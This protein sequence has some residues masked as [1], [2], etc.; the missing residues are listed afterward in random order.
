MGLDHGDMSAANVTA[1]HHC[2]SD[3]RTHGAKVDHYLRP[4]RVVSLVPSWTE[5]LHDLDSHVVGQ[6]KFCVRPRSAFRSVDRIGG[7]KTIDVEKIL[8][9][10]PDM[11]VANKEENNREQVQ[12]LMARCP[13]HCEVVVTDIRSL[14]SVWRAMHQLGESLE[15]RQETNQM[16]AQ[17]QE[18]WGEAKPLVGKAGYAVWSKPWMAAGTDTFIHHVMQHWGIGNAVKGTSRYPSLAEESSRGVPHAPLWLLP[19]EPFPFQQKHLAALQED[20]PLAA[21]RLV[22]GEAFSWYGSRML[23]VAAHLQEVADWVA[24]CSPA[25]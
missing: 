21:F 15:K 13:A 14:D 19:S 17:I 5:F 18:H 1:S 16:V 7:T 6:T 10:Q 2:K 25:S 12:Q 4:M 23:H 24:K 8:G 9:L 3:W 11:V 22:D 20:H